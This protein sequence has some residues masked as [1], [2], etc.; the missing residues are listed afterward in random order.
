MTDH[1]VQHETARAL[2]L[3]G[4]VQDR[5]FPLKALVFAGH[6]LVQQQPLGQ[7]RCDH[8]Q[9]ALIVEQADVV[10]HLPSCSQHTQHGLL[11]F[12]WHGHEGK[13]AIG[14]R[15]KGTGAVDQLRFLA[16]VS[17]NQGHA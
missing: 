7:Q 14:F 1:I 15:M 12:E 5:R 13:H 11:D 9:D 8:G 2:P 6:S 16:H 3:Q 4:L 10:R 17:D